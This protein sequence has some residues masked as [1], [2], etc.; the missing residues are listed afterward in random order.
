M[1]AG[2]RLRKG[3][4]ISRKKEGAGLGGGVLILLS[5]YVGQVCDWYAVVVLVGS[6]HMVNNIVDK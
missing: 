2:S 1:R 6:Y 5:L 4:L 3:V